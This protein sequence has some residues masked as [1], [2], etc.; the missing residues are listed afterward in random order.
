MKTYAETRG[1]RKAD[2]QER[3]EGYA[4]EGWEEEHGDDDPVIEVVET[5]YKNNVYM[6]VTTSSNGLRKTVQLLLL[7][8][9]LTRSTHE[10]N[11]R[12]MTLLLEVK[13]RKEKS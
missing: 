7:L 6:L 1:E 13:E 4:E 12:T 3:V 2:E 8:L 5:S 11:L 10:F 9:L